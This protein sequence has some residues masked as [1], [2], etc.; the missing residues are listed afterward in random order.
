[1][2]KKIIAILLVFTLVITCFVACQ[3]KKLDTV[4][5]NGEEVAIATDEDGNT[6]VNDENQLA[7]IVTDFDGEVITYENGEDQ[8]RW[9]DVGS[10]FVGDG[11]VMG[12]NYRFVLLEGWNGDVL[13]RAVKDGTD[14]KCYIQFVK[15]KEIS[16]D[17]TVDIYFE[18]L[19]AQNEQLI[20]GLKK[21]GLTLTVDT[22]ET[23][24]KTYNGLH[25][26]YKIVDGDGKVVHYA[27]NY[28][29]VVGTIIYS[30][31]YACVDGVGYDETFNF[32]S[33]VNDNFK[34]NR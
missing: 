5:I 30:V 25:Y 32:G 31:N 23:T 3:K 15:S 34:F 27:E 4:T 8:T 26:V 33:Y 7:V 24:V 18:N 16:E 2:S 14:Q 1:M 28:Y 13:G 22:N 10:G 20:E 6:M 21:E 9:V 12:E 17:E 29:F 11:Y 19:D